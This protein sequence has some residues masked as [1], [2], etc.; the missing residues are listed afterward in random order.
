MKKHC[1]VFWF[2]L[3]IACLLLLTGF[4]INPCC[5]A[6]DSSDS[7]GMET[8]SADGNAVTEDDSSGAIRFILKRD[9][10]QKLPNSDDLFVAFSLVPGANGTRD[11]HIHGG[12]HNDNLYLFDGIDTTEPL[13]SMLGAVP[14]ADTIESIEFLT[15]ALPAQYGRSMGG[16]INGLTRP[17]T[18]DFHGMLRYKRVDTNTRGSDEWEDYR[19]L[20]DYDYHDYAVTVDGPILKDKLW[21]MISYHFYTEEE[22]GTYRPSGY[23]SNWNYGSGSKSYTMD[24]EHQY[25]VG[26][27]TWQPNS[28]HRISII[29][30]HQTV[31]WNNHS[32]PNYNATPDTYNTLEQSDPFYGA[33]WQWDVNSDLALTAFIGEYYRATDD[34]PASGNTNDP[35]FYDMYYG[36]SY[37][38]SQSWIEDDRRRFQYRLTAEY[39]LDDWFGSH[40]WVSGIEYQIQE[41]DNLYKIPGGASY[42]IEQ[43][44]VGDPDHPDYYSGEEASRTIQLFPG[45]SETCG[46]YMA[47]FLQDDWSVMDDITLHLGIRY[48]NMRYE[49]ADGDTSV[50][51]WNWGEFKSEDYLKWGMGQSGEFEPLRN[52]PM[53]FDTMLAPRVGVEWDI[54]GDGATR[55]SAFYGRYYDP[56]DMSLPAMFQP[57]E[58]DTYATRQQE[59]SGPAWT[60]RNR[61]GIPDE[62]FFFEDT[63]WWTSSEDT[64]GASNLIDPD[65]KPEYTDEISIGARHDLTPDITVGITYINRRTRDLIED[66]G[67]FTDYD[68]NI[69]W[70]YRGGVNDDFSGLDPREK[71]D[72]RDT[73][74]DYAH[75]IYWITNAD[76]NRRDYNGVDL[77]VNIHK[78][79]WDMLASY[80]WSE[81]EGTVTEAPPGSTGVAQFSGQYDTYSVSQNLYGELPWSCR[82]YLKLAGSYH[83]DLTDWYEMSFGINSY[84]HSGYHYSKRTTPP[85]TFDPDDESNVYDDPSTWTG[86][87]PYRA[88]PWYYPEGRGT[89]ELPSEY[90]IDLSWQNRFTL[91]NAGT[92]TVIVDVNNVTDNQEIVSESDIYNPNRP[93]DFGTYNQW[94]TP[95]EY[96]WSLVYS[97]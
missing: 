67:L 48:E 56:F 72:P 58:K 45:S 83:F 62:S 22:T 51:A 7:G 42:T 46:R 85:R 68:G 52:A 11:I 29:F 25:P 36:V 21:F 97:F 64:E 44:P 76:E 63:N 24:R 9:M 1:T 49:N 82:H 19:T 65:L 23:P 38:N 91:G 12:A 18:N 73:G 26:R 15:G 28:N 60:D 14:Y 86:R 88:Y 31:T 33:E 27:L 37:N 55:I 87:P 50:P 77:T 94:K 80:T 54:T 92:L 47:F 13:T 93:E 96:R 90:N 41:V 71:Y 2:F 70:T 35:A 30:S 4:P 17:G 79:A 32:G 43:S 81:A 3:L 78:P 95:R 84:L 53:E 40:E 66:V 57:F 74:E 59:Y 34:K 89:Y 5:R 6:A 75:H 8:D 16:V 20:E 39:D 61:D 10:L 69:V